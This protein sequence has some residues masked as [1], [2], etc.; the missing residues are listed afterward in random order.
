[1]KIT[2][3]MGAGALLMATAC[4][5]PRNTSNPTTMNTDSTTNTTATQSSDGW[6]SLFDGQTLN[7]WRTYQNKPT[8]AWH[9]Q[10]GV[11]HCTGNETYK[12][13]LQVDLITAEKYENFDFSIDWKISPK[14]NSGIMYL[15][16]ETA[17]AAYETG[18]EYQLI[19]D[20]NFPEKLEDWQTT[21]ANYAM[22]PAP[23]AKPAPVGE[24]NNTRIVVNNS[25]VEHWLNGTKVVE[26]TLGSDEWN[27]AKA[28]G[29]WKDTPGYG[30]AKRGHIALQDHGSEAWFKNIKIKKL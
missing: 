20:A 29:K 21:A 18:P 3:L 13:D 8:E 24:W 27:Q 17:P 12:S 9:V 25:R 4:S 30:M 26:Y 16:Q 10:D 23:A 19:D 28:T 15:V 6:I 22:H 7:G 2:M 5:A 14:G 11:L 1:M